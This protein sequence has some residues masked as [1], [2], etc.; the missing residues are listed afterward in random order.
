[1]LRLVLDEH[2]HIEQH[3]LEQTLIRRDATIRRLCAVLTGSV[4]A[5]LASQLV[6]LAE[7]GNDTPEG[8][9]LAFSLT[10]HELAALIGTTRETVSIELGRLERSRLILRRGRQIV[11]RDIPRLRVHAR[12]DPP[13][14]GSAIHPSEKTAFIATCS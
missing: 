9:E 8:R 7:H 3:F 2:L 14:H 12:D 4:R 6:E 10:H 5:R 13:L 1:V 11:V